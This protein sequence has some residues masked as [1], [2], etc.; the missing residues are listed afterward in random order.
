MGAKDLIKIERWNLL[1]GGTFILVAA[2][3]FATPVL[4]GVTA[5]AVLSCANFA[6]MRKLV[7]ATLGARGPRKA[8]FQLLLIGKMGVLFVLVFLAIRF[9]P[10]NPA[11][12]AVGLSVFL[13]SIGIESLRFALGQ[14]HEAPDG[15]A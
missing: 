5:G 8:V 4:V 15:R 10:M 2:L 12:F 3:V 13:L 11:A 14:D 1:L 9:L 7:A 6:G